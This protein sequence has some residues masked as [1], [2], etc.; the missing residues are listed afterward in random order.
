MQAAQGG[1]HTMEF[2]P[3]TIKKQKNI[4]LIAHD[5]KKHELMEWCKANKAI[6]EKHFLCGTGTTSK[7]DHRLYRSSCK[8]IQQ[9]PIARRPA[10]RRQRS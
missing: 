5:Q 4:A 7:D 10:D 2:I 6:L 1:M 9:R 8:R 3:M